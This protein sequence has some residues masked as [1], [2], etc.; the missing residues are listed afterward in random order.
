MTPPLQ[1]IDE[2]AR[3]HALR[4]YRLLDTL[5]EPAFDEL[6]ALVAHICEVPIALITLID[7]ERQW[8]KSKVGLSL[9]ES[10]REISF[11]GHTILNRKMF[12]VPD[13]TQ[14]VRFADNPFVTGEPYLSFYAGVPLL[15]PHGQAIGSLAVIDR[16]PRQL[17]PSQQEILWVLSRQ[18]MSQLELRCQARELVESEAQLEKALS[19]AHLGEQRMR[20]VID[21]LGP[22][23]FVGLLACDG[24]LLQANQPALSAA[25]LQLEDVLGKP[26]DQT[27]WFGYSATV[28]EQL[29]TAVARAAAGQASRYDV[30]I[31]VAEGSL[32]WLDFS[33]EPVRDASGR[34][35][36]LVPS[37]TVIEERKRAE[38]R[39]EHLNRVYAVLSDIN[40]TIVHQQDPQVM[41]TAACRI[42]VEKG[43]FC[44]AWIGLVEEPG[45]HLKIAAHANATDDTLQILRSLVGGEQ[46]ACAFT[47]QALQTGRHGVC[48][49][50]QHDPQ[51]VVWRSAALQRGF[52]AMAALPL[53][54]GETVIGTLNIYADEPGFFD[55][56]ELALLDDLA[57]DISFALEVG[58]REEKRR[59]AEEELRWKTAFFEAQV[60][61]SLD[62]ILVVDKH[63]KKIL[64]NRRMIELWKIPAEMAAEEDDAAQVRFVT[65][66]TKHPREFVER[67]TYLYSHPDEVSREI[68][69]LTDGTFLDRSSSP[70]RDKT[71]KLY[72]RIWAFRDITEQRKLEEQL[73]QSQKMEAIGQLAGG[74][75]HDFNNLLTVIHGYGV[76]LMTPEE[77]PAETKLAVSQIVRAAERAADLTRQLLAFSR[78][79]V[80]HTRLL[81]LNEIVTSLAKM[82]QRILG[83]DISLQLN[84]CSR[85]LMTR[86]DAGMLDQ[87]LL[88][89]VVNARDA[90]PDGGRLYIETGVK[91]FV[92]KDVAANPE[93]STGSFVSLRVTDTGNGIRPENLPR[94]FEPFFTTKEVGKGTGLGLA[95]VFG[96][97][98]Q[99]GGSI[100]VESGVG[101]GTA[102][103]LYLP[104]AEESIPPLSPHAAG[105][106]SN[107]R[108][109]TETI[110]LVEDDSAVRKLTRILLERAGY[111]IVEA[112]HGL[113]ALVVAEKYPDKI[114]LL[115]TD[116][117]MPEGLSGR[118]LAARLQERDP[119]LRVIFSSGYSAEIAGRK[120][121]LQAGQNFIQ[122]P[123]TREQLLE[124]VRRCLD[125]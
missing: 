62:G 17:S 55:A 43:R 80:M 97:M 75:A 104:G 6:T 58:R 56:D 3:L 9:V 46:S 42:A 47:L 40:Q 93:L 54:A 1:S 74:V 29:R 96:I 22:N 113:D 123:A 78:R 8:F 73:R 99:H 53:Q 125:S 100:M 102:F 120:L 118:E 33:I 103:Q 86:A 30:Q 79:Q 19:A 60:D 4:R 85:P 121:A 107:P 34:V 50:I 26:V 25:G 88:N 109:G 77:S 89:L 31:R 98:K 39:I 61:S 20:K 65:S 117:V 69:E 18:V 105:L 41:L 111:K 45:R 5:P 63:G 21:G 37:A 13:A 49:D 7:E 83:E 23:N 87:V 66:R 82:L 10:S 94:I 44:M 119:A 110:L 92:A 24:T 72:G 36:H 106:Q 90:M 16:V 52:R 59:Q 71:G 48:N 15:T 91:I 81:D 28:Q 14:D 68:I 101:R 35:I 11:C 67:I 27:Y 12:V 108:G 124:I 114:H 32:I 57:M 116:I 70:V 115:F 122:K 95:T 64:Q 84:L 76:M 112:A 38:M 2:V 51:A